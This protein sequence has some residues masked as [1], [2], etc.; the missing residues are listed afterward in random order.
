MAYSKE[1]R[2]AYDRAYRDR[3]KE[4]LAE[5]RKARDLAK[6]SERT[7]YNKQRYAEN[8]EV[9]ALS[10]KERYAANRE[11]YVAARRIRYTENRELYAGAKRAYYAANTEAALRIAVR[12]FFKVPL[13]SVPHELVELKIAQLKLGRKLKERKTT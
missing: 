7:A 6:S 9:M 10:W 8:K 13:S 2:Q 11:K 4:R 5:K 1:D 3:N 12:S